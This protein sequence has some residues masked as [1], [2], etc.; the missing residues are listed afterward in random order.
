[1]S[2]KKRRNMSKTMGG[3]LEVIRDIDSNRRNE[4][5]QVC[6]ESHSPL[7]SCI[8]KKWDCVEE[9]ALQGFKFQNA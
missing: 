9:Q 4:V 2:E 1:M 6:V 7:W 5:A 8:K 3:K